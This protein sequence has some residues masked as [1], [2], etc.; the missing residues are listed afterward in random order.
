MRTMGLQ[1]MSVPES[2]AEGL[3]Y[4]ATS[5]ISGKTSENMR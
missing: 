5:A 2:Q 4:L 3:R 1:R